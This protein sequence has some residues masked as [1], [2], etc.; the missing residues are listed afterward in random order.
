MVECLKEMLGLE[1][2][3]A[4]PPTYIILDALDETSVLSRHPFHHHRE[5]RSWSFWTSSL[6]FTSQIYTYALRV[7]RSMTFALSSNV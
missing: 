4:Q 3:A 2:Q 6:P 1:A 7:G 5:K